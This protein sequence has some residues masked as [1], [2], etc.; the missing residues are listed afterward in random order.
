MEHGDWDAL[1]IEA[2]A[3]R[4]GVSKATIYRRWL[5]KEGLLA[6]LLG[7]IIDAYPSGPDTGDISEDLLMV[8]RY[9]ANML[10][11]PFGRSL[12]GTV[13]LSTNPEL[14]AAAEQYWGYQFSGVSSLVQR[15]IRQGHIRPD[16]DLEAISE[17]L[18]AP[19]YIR[20]MI[21]K[22]ALDTESL[23]QIVERALAPYLINE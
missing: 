8:V 2:I 19:V 18:L 12:T 4:S 10:Q 20:A 3:E 5:D 14:I 6:E 1:S 16:A 23:R 9:L 21:T 13:A 11:T 22:L 17:A 7:E 15:G